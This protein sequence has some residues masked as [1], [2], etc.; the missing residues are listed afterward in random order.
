MARRFT[1]HYVQIKLPV[2]RL[3]MRL[4]VDFTS[5]YVQI[6]LLGTTRQAVRDRLYIPL[7]SD[8]T[9]PAFHHSL[10]LGMR[11]YIPLRSDKTEFHLGG[12]E[13]ADDFTSHYVQIK[14][15]LIGF[16]VIVFRTSFTSHYVQIKPSPRCPQR[17]IPP[18]LHPTTFR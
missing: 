2:T 5:H 3:G 8:K 14:L 15:D 6:K 12:L 11:L 17:C 9:L 7:R 1:S 10:F 4:K 18:A 16:L 13:G